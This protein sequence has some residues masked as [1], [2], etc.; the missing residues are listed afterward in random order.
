M[1]IE[2]LDAPIKNP[3]QLFIDGEWVAPSTDATIDVIAPATEQLYLRVA[4]AKEADIERAVAAA[5]LAFDEGPWPRMSHAERAGYLTAIAE[6]LT[7][8][9]PDVA[10][11]WPNEM[12]ILHSMAK[13]YSA[14]VAG[15][16]SYYASLATRFPFEEERRT[17]SGAKLGLLVREPV[18]VVGAII[19]WNGPISL[20]AFKIAPAL[21]AGCTVVIKASPEAPGHALLMAEVA[22]SV[23]LPKGVVNVVTADRQASE[24]LVRH[25]GI[26]K[27]AFTGSTAA[28]TRIASILGERMARYTLELGGKSA[29]I[30]LDDYD[31]ETAARTIAEHAGDMTGQ[32]CASLTRVVVT[33]DRHDR[34]VE[35][36]AAS[37][38][39]IRV[40]DPFDPASQMGP[41]A[42]Q[43]Q[44]DRVEGYIA[45][46]RADGFT[47]ATGGGRPAHL[48]RGYYVEPTVF[49]HVDNRSRLGQEEV[50]GPVL[51]VIPAADEADAVRIANDSP[52]GLNGAVFTNDIDRAYAVARQV[53]TGTMGHNAIR[54][55]FSIAFG[56]FKQSGVGRE[57]GVEGLHPYLETKTVLLDGRPSHLPMRDGNGR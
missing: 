6:K 8:R 16:Y 45:G 10:A 22:E 13:D 41:L 54:M 11:I 12:G 51:A 2:T 30:V 29:A 48:N 49:G 28:G 47:L 3:G 23:G 52:F 33:R 25:P 21:L 46:A 43:R 32:V 42:T 24:A 31:V 38:G 55:D 34:L 37:F 7:E 50:F 18:G 19:P 4:E 15:L 53:R 5:R 39:A 27:I 26:D 20:I 35:A 1:T 9:L 40:G 36:L 44:R 56:G 57:G 17:F 14:G